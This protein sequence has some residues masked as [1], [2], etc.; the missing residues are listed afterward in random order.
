[1]IAIGVCVVSAFV[2]CVSA[3][4]LRCAARNHVLS[5]SRALRRQRRGSTGAGVTA[6]PPA[7]M[8]NEFAAH[9]DVGDRRLF[10]SLPPTDTVMVA[11]AAVHPIQRSRGQVAENVERL[12]ERT[13]ELVEANKELEAFSHSVSHDLKAPLRAINGFAGMLSDQ[14]APQLDERGR[15]Y[16][17]RVLDAA[18]RMEG[19]IDDL[20]R[21]SHVSA[22]E[23]RRS[24]VDMSRM[25][26]VII[27]DLRG[28]EPGRNVGTAIDTGLR[29]Q[30]DSRLLRIA[31]E[32]LLGNAWK[33]TRGVE[34]AHIEVGRDVGVVDGYFVRDNGAGFNLEYA[35]NIFAPFR[36]LHSAAEFS[37]TGVGLS[38]VQRIIHRHGGRINAHGS[39]GNG[40]EFHFTLP[41]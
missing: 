15:H 2:L 31:L 28:R 20:M 7:A 39:V 3:H 22:A 27:E 35:E 23:L 38:I 25:A 11:D 29:C 4:A 14:Y 33:F 13:R 8:C 6:F 24:D 21:L 32:N 12:Q 18:S 10:R 30:A 19:L 36:R 1:M 16:V 40:A 41:S 9:R 26:A 37:G 34:T 17:R 5:F